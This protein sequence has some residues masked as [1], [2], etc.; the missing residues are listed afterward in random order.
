[1]KFFSKIIGKTNKIEKIY[2]YIFLASIVAGIIYGALDTNYHKSY[3]ESLELQPGENSA[4]IFFSNFVLSAA[5]LVTAGIASLYFNFNT[6]AIISSFLASQGTLFGLPL[7]FPVAFFEFFGV[8]LFGLS[9]LSLVE[10]KI[11]KRKSALKIWSLLK[12]GMVLLVFGA[13][14]EVGLIYLLS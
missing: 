5:N 12:Y 10:R 14:I 13:L 11:F 2:I 1:M 8:M 7:F 9:G 6:F 3:Q 4:T